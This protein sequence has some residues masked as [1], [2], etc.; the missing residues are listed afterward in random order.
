MTKAYHSTNKKDDTFLPEI[1]GKH[2]NSYSYSWDGKHYISYG[3][4]LAAPRETKY[5][6]GNRLI[7]RQVLGKKLNCTVISEDFIIDQSVFI[8]KPRELYSK[9]IYAIQGFLA[10][11]LI[12]KYFRFTSNEFDALFPKIK[13][14]EFK[15]L[16]VFRDLEKADSILSAKVIQVLTAKKINP[17]LDTIDLEKEID[18]LVYQ[19]YGLTDEEIKIVE[20]K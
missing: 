8:A 9:Y 11:T 5:F 3:E 16:P 17:N 1:R 4:W 15:E 20:G 18:Q 2:V 13:I 12:S 10:S 19:L 14:G 6:T 7:M